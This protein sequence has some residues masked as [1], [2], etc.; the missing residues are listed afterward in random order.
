MRRFSLIKRGELVNRNNK[1]G[2]GEHNKG[3][4][5][6]KVYLKFPD[7]LVKYMQH[8]KRI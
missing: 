1:I 2:L 8:T 3:N 4:K 5:G 7:I 6:I